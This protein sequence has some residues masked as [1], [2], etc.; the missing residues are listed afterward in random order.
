MLRK[1][2]SLQGSQK[3]GPKSCIPGRVVTGSDEVAHDTHHWVAVRYIWNFISAGFQNNQHLGEDDAYYSNY[4]NLLAI[5]TSDTS[6]YSKSHGRLPA[7]TMCHILFWYFIGRPCDLEL[8]IIAWCDYKKRNNVSCWS[9]YLSIQGMEWRSPKDHQGIGFLR[10]A[11]TQWLDHTGGLSFYSSSIE[12]PLAGP[13]TIAWINLMLMQP[14]YPWCQ[15]IITLR[16]CKW[17]SNNY[18]AN[19]LLEIYIK[20][21]R[22]I[23]NYLKDT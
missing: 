22:V 2:G 13:L 12:M 21:T 15:I 16:H 23:V 4:C 7:P 10:S 19:T 11:R 9:H 3:T 20:R 8:R 6:I 17:T 5:K 14:M 18:F 1:T